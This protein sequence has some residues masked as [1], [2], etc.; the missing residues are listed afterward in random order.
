MKKNIMGNIKD[1][2]SL[3]IILGLKEEKEEILM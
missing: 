1:T 2:T 3:A